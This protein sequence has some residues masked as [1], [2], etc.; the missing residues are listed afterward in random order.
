MAYCTPTDVQAWFDGDRLAY[1]LYDDPA[2]ATPADLT[3]R[4]AAVIDEVCGV[5]D[6]FLEGL[7]PLPLPFTSR[8]L[9]KLATDLTIYELCARRGFSEN[10]ADAVIVDKQKNA[11]RLLEMLAAGKISLR[12]S[13]VPAPER[14]VAAEVD[15]DPRVFSRRSMRGF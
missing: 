5:I 6:G 2:Q 3:D 11:M 1:L 13:D 10:T 4:V 15:A 14:N 8:L 7:Y 12:R 9:Q